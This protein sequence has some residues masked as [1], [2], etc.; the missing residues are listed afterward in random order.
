M[1]IHQHLVGRTVEYVATDGDRLVIRTTC[2]HEVRIVWT[3]DEGRR[4]GEPALEGVDVRI[5]LPM[6]AAQGTGGSV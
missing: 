6:A 3:D 5:V 1:K 4:H 2:G